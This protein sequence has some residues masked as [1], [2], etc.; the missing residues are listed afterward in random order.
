MANKR[1]RWVEDWEGAWDTD[2]DN[3]FLFNE[4]GP[5]EDSFDFCPYCGKKLACSHYKCNGTEG[6]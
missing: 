5:C 1:C 4:G 6:R 3:R 2:C